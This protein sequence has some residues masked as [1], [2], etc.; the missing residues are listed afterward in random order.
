MTT[1]SQD[2]ERR[3]RD[4]YRLLRDAG[5]DDA[6]VDELMAAYDSPYVDSEN[7]LSGAELLVPYTPPRRS[8][9]QGLM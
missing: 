8:P 5:I 7:P 4:S 3:L 6:T 9:D 2:C 1:R